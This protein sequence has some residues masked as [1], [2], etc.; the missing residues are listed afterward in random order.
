MRNEPSRTEPMR[1]LRALAYGIALISAIVATPAAAQSC[2]QNDATVV[3]EG[4]PMFG[5]LMEDKDFNLNRQVHDA[6]HGLIYLMGSRKEGAFFS[7]RDVSYIVRCSVLGGLAF[8]EAKDFQRASESS[9]AATGVGTGTGGSLLTASL[10]EAAS[11]LGLTIVGYLDAGPFTPFHAFRWTELGGVQDLGTLTPSD[12]ASRSS[13]ATAVSDD[14]NVVVGYSDVGNGFTIHAF[15]WTAATGMVDLGVPAGATRS[16]RALDANRDGTVI[17]GEAD[18][19]DA[20]QFTGI[21]N[22]AFRWTAAS[23]MQN[24][25]ALQPGYFTRANDVSPDG[26]TVV[27]EGGVE[28]V[29]GTSSTNGSRAFRWSASSGLQSLG[30]LTGH[31]FADATAVSDDGK[32]IV[33]T[34]SPETGPS[35]AFRWTQATG[36][37]DLRQILV[38]AG[39]TMTGVQ[40]LTAVSVTGDGQFI[41][42]AATTPTTPAGETDSYMVRFCDTATVSPCPQISFAPGNP[43]FSLTGGGSSSLSVVA[44][45]SANTSLTI[46]PAGGF[47]RQVAFSCSGLPAG[48]GCSFSPAT[49]TASSATSTTLTVTTTAPT[50]T[51]GLG[52]PWIVVMLIGW[53]LLFLPRRRTAGRPAFRYSLPAALALVASCGGSGD[54]GTNPPP[55]PSGG[56]PAGSYAL[57]ITA[58]TATGAPV[59]TRTVTLTLNVTR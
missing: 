57:T 45:Q 14:G 24:L 3:S 40:L 4:G 53:T 16:A 17:V 27:G 50:T 12:N 35:V 43:D 32:V 37:Q 34:S 55:P 8:I 39:L 52:G 22:S 9:G 44:G 13:R 46:T 47:N 20:A 15:R 56:T 48:V 28:I 2:Y 10:E 38:T 25:G 7:A 1:K 5:K 23:G 21:R 29:A 41:G 33:G 11:F 31:R 30:T 58:T 49:V 42:G 19:P 26:S 36:M 59:L 51:S 54:G 18:F 6:Q